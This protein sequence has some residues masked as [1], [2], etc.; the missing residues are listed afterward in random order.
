MVRG[1]EREREERRGK[2]LG[3]ERGDTKQ[4]TSALCVIAGRSAKG[5]SG[6]LGRFAGKVAQTAKGI[7][8]PGSFPMTQ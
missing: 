7:E 2:G 6:V 3:R 8:P 1:K 4:Q 5:S